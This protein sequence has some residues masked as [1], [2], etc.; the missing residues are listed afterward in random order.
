[1]SRLPEITK[2]QKCRICGSKDLSMITCFR[3][4]PL[5]DAFRKMDDDSQEFLFDIEIFKC[6]ICNTAQT[7][8][9]VEVKDYYEDYQYSV[10]A[11]PGASKFMNLLAERVITKYFRSEKPS[12]LKILEVGSGDGVQLESFKKLGCSTLG[13][14]PSST[15]CSVAASRGIESIHDLFNKD[16]LKQIPA[17]FQRVD[18]V[19]LSY[20]FDH[21]PDP[22]DFLK[23]ARSILDSNRGVLV[24]EVHDLDKIFD[25]SEFCL[26]EHE[27]S[28]Y[29]NKSTA[30]QLLERTG[31][32]I[33]TFDLLLDN[34]KRA[35]SLLFVATP[36]GS[37]YQS[38]LLSDI[39]I[40]NNYYTNGISKILESI[41]NLDRF[42]TLYGGDSKNLVGYGAGGRGVMTLAAMNQS[43]R[44]K[45]LIDRNPKGNR[46]VA[47]KSHVPTFG[48]SWFEHNPVD[49]VLVF[50]FGYLDEIISDL[51][52]YGI[53]DQK[54]FS[55]VDV[56]KGDFA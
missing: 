23:S 40:D 35:N 2:L 46:I 41:R 24:V 28:I 7:Q 56:L 51:T 44:F 3:S 22:I 25:R 50:S 11:S 8:H 42:A 17:D 49:S 34:E 29:L 9:D 6:L 32:S 20:T 30:I 4:M 43:N 1:M 38:E 14:E 15:L 21:I 48:L 33:L 36:T 18:A 19:V 54:I 5:T 13:Y 39:V 27:H 31:F 37:R 52:S 10:G 26:F 55:L 47:P 53:S 16:S 12:D 45:A